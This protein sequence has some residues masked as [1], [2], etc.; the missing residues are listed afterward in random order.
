MKD[1]IEFARSEVKDLKGDNEERK[2]TDELTKQQ[3]EKLE[4]GNEILHKER[5]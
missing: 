4:K 1:S 2:K 5:H 3:I